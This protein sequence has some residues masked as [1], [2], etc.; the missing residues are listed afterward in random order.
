MKKISLI[1]ALFP[2][3][4]PEVFAQRSL[5]SEFDLPGIPSSHLGIWLP[6]TAMEKFQTNLHYL[7]AW[8]GSTRYEYLRVTAKNIWSGIHDGFAITRTEFPKFQ[9]LQDRATP[10][11]I[12]PD[13]KRYTQVSSNGDAS[14]FVVLQTWLMD[15][16]RSKMEKEGPHPV[17]KFAG[18]DLRFQI[19]SPATE[20]YRILIDGWA[21][22]EIYNRELP[23]DAYQLVLYASDR[24]RVLGLRFEPDHL[25]VDQI[26][27]SLEM[28]GEVQQNVKRQS[29]PLYRIWRK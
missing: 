8:E 22:T 6:T 25:V 16:V 24:S 9:F 15:Q 17:L 10:V 1:L 4:T 7:D 20:P 12:D 5:G 23:S 11:I 29:S 19:G 13:G 27:T 3:L 21:L 14:A 28:R 18:P 26:I 2:L